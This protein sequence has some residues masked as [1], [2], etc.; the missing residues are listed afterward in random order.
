[1]DS[2]IYE[3]RQALMNHLFYA[4][5]MLSLGMPDVCAALESEDGYT[6]ADD[7]KRWYRQ[8][9]QP[10][11]PALSEDDMYSLRCGV[12]HRGRLNDPRPGLQY[13][14]IVFTLPSNLTLTEGRFNNVYFTDAHRFCADMIASAEKWYA[15]KQKDTNVEKNILRLVQYRAHGLKPYIV[16]VPVV[17]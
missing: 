7:Y 16:G 14:R 15:A 9:F 6:K 11:Y 10:K 5:I 12:F 3:I 13:E 4:A 17:A 2:I 8:W 1:M